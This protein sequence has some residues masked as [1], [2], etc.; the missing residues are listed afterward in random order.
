MRAQKYFLLFSKCLCE[1][2]KVGSSQEELKI[3]VTNE[4][5][6]KLA[7]KGRFQLSFINS[8]LL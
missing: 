2:T 5:E 7:Y 8:Q 3:M 6:L 1:L 4:V